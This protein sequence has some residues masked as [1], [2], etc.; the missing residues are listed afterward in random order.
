M[1]TLI[2]RLLSVANVGQT[3]N[4]FQMLGL[5]SSYHR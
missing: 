3:L 1:E 2:Q 5:M 4:V